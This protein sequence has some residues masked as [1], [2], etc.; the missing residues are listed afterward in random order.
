MQSLEL[1]NDCP[2]D[3]DCTVDLLT[4]GKSAEVVQFRSVGRAHFITEMSLV[5]IAIRRGDQQSDVETSN[6][7]WRPAIA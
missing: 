5:L 3:P 6:Q 1:P 2:S 7:T 4:V